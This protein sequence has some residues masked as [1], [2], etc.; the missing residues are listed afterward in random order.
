MQ[1]LTKLTWNSVTTIIVALFWACSAV[2]SPAQESAPRV[3]PRYFGF[4]IPLGAYRAG[5]GRRVTTAD[6]AGKAVVAKLHVEVGSHRIVLLPDGRLV[7]RRSTDAPL[8]ERPFVEASKDDLAKQLTAKRFA[9]FKTKQDVRY[10]YVYNCSDSFALAT[11]S[12]MKSM[13]RGVELHAKAQ[14]IDVHSPEVPMVV[15]MFRTEEQFQRHRRMPEGVV[16]YYDPISNHVV[17]YEESK[18]AGVDMKLAIQQSLSVIAHEGA[19]QI[20]HNIG[21][22]Q[23]LSVWPMWL[24]EGLAEYFAPTTTGAKLRWKGAGQV[25]DMRMHELE[26]YLKLAAGNGLDG[27]TIESTVIAPRLTST[28]YASAWSL[29]HYLAKNHRASFNKFVNEASKLGPLEGYLRSASGSG[30]KQ[31]LDSF[32]QFFGD[33]L[34]GMEVRLVAHLKKLPYSPPFASWPHFVV[35]IEYLDGKRVQRDGNM[36]HVKEMA[37]RWQRATLANLPKGARATIQRLPDRS[38]ADLI[39]RRWIYGG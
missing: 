26:E 39:L 37:D 11:S 16:A 32:K 30:I 9:G 14:R 3:D 27:K 6:D 20:L 24:A 35:L 10:L 23:R 29:T 18:L 19:H 34:K 25:N 38:K 2:K 33:D 7:A 28:G 21:V 4:D 15:V 5:D 13:Y 22:Q 36:F 8:T 17:M 1:P 12:I 31:N